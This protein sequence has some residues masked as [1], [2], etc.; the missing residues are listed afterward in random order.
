MSSRF[1]PRP[2]NAFFQE[3]DESLGIQLEYQSNNEKY[4]IQLVDPEGISKMKCHE[5]LQ[6]IKGQV[7]LRDNEI[8]KLHPNQKGGRVLVEISAAAAE[9]LS[10]VYALSLFY[11]SDSESD[12]DR[13]TDT[14]SDRSKKP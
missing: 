9:A 3:V 4:P 2:L 12:T 14:P 7:D 10:E 13:D 6:F 11:D 5:L 1:D 8:S